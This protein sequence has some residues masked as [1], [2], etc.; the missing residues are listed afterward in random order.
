MEH[1][2]IAG[3]L[4]AYE[5]VGPETM[6]GWLTQH[7]WLT[8]IPQ[9]LN[10]FRKSEP[11]IKLYLFYDDGEL[12]FVEKDDKGE[13][14]PVEAYYGIKHDNLDGRI[15]NSLW[16]Q[17]DYMALLE[18]IVDSNEDMS[19]KTASLRYGEINLPDYGTLRSNY[20]YSDRFGLKRETKE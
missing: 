8:A 1:Y 4:T 17:R 12:V 9:Q 10:Q 5:D 2:V 18:T 19:M 20:I 3:L 6:Q 16:L 14:T 15:A 11:T 7:W 13:R